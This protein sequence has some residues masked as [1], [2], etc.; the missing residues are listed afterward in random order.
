MTARTDPSTPRYRRRI[1]LVALGA[2]GAMTLLGTPLSA[3][4]EVNYKDGEVGNYQRGIVRLMQR[5]HDVVDEIAG[6]ALAS[7]YCT[8][9]DLGA[10]ANLLHNGVEC[11]SPSASATRM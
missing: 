8:A 2:L 7:T 5:S 1:H 6:I 3:Q 4:V 11:R 10:F 9:K